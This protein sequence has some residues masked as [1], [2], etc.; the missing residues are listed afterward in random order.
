MASPRDL[1]SSVLANDERYCPHCDQVVKRRT[2]Y[3]HRKDYFDEER[4]TWRKKVKTSHDHAITSGAVASNEE[5]Y[6]CQLK[7]VCSDVNRYINVTCC[8]TLNHE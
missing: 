3:D 8:Y 4:G 6:S 1:A 2:F 7:Q 5:Q